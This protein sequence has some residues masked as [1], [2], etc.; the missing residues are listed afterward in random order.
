[1][2]LNQ[3]NRISIHLNKG[4]NHRILLARQAI[5]QLDP[6]NGQKASIA[7]EHIG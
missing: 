5:R 4:I 6:S 3:L 7:V 1:M 2:R